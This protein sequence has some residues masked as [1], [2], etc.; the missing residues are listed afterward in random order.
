ME[1]NLNNICSKCFD[2]YYFIG[3]RKDKCETGFNLNNYFTEDYGISYYPCNTS[4]TG[5]DECSSR[6]NCT[7]C[8]NEYYLVGG[9]RDKCHY[10]TCRCF[11]R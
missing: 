10:W 8:K 7:I 9:R 1:E 11:M 3:L 6:Y 5:C 4:V 2:G